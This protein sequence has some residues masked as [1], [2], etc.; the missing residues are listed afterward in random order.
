MSATANLYRS[1]NTA[2]TEGRLE[3]VLQR[4]KE[5]AALHTGLKKCTPTLVDALRKDLQTTEESAAEE[6]RVVLD[7]VKYLYDS[8]DFPGTLAGE[9]SVKKGSSGGTLVPLGP[10]LIDPSPYAPVSSSLIPLAAA[11]AAGSGAIVLAPR[12]APS[13]SAELKKIIEDSL[14]KEAVGVTEDDSSNTRQQLG[15]KHFGVA[16]LQNL[17]E[18]GAL[19]KLLYECNPLVRIFTPPAGFPVVFIDRSVDD[20]ETV[21][22]HIHQVALRNHRQNPL[23]VPRLCFVDEAVI[24]D[25]ENL[26]HRPIANGTES[27]QVNGGQNKIQALYKTL[28]TT[29]PSLVEKFPKHSPSS[30]P[31]VVALNSSE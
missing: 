26:L 10:T 30:I 21:A 22:S 20:L 2:W 28:T 13:T 18:R 23:R 1:V 27:L 11:I 5:L 3:N 29:F 4:K 8:L 24:T 25:F 12:A 14:D 9:R 31:S 17:D 15:S 19:L 7:A 16:V 6:V